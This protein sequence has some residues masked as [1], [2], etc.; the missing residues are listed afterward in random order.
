MAC[1]MCVCLCL[2]AMCGGRQVMLEASAEAEELIK[3]SEKHMQEKLQTQIE[4]QKHREL[5]TTVESNTQERIRKM[6]A[7]RTKE[8]WLRT[9]SSSLE[10][11]VLFLF[12]RTF[13]RST[14]DNIEEDM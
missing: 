12:A 10:E 13:V 14:C 3:M 4:I 1:A 9:L 6:Y 11:K 8:E 7:S 2:C 5:A